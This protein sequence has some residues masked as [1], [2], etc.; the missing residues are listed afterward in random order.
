M[1]V[2]VASTEVILGPLVPT[3]G[4]IIGD[5]ILAVFNC[6]EGLFETPARCLLEVNY[7]KR[8]LFFNPYKEFDIENKIL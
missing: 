2:G 5:A 4:V 7:H 3:I 8:L 1:C 6:L